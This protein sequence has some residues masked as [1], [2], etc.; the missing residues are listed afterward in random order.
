MKKNL[1]ALVLAGVMVLTGCARSTGLETEELTISCYKGVEISEVSKPEE[2]TDEE[3]EYTIQMNLEANATTKEITDRAVKSGDT[4]D[5]NFVGTTDGVAFEGGTAENYSLVIGS[6]EFIDGFEESVIGHNIGDTYDFAGT[7]EEG[8][9]EEL[10]GK[11]FVFSITVNAITEQ[12]IP[13]FNDEFVQSVS[14]ESK[15]T[16]EYREEIKKTLEENYQLQYESSIKSLAWQA[17]LDNTEV[18]YYP[19]AV[20][21]SFDSLI[22]QYKSIAEFYSMDYT[23]FIEAQMQTTV[24]EFETQMM[25]EVKAAETEVMVSQ[26]IAEKEKITMDDAKFEEMLGIMAEQYGYENADAVREA[27]SEEDLKEL[28]ITMLVMDFVAEHAMQV[29]E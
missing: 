3:V 14:E 13:E 12:V 2:V 10:G 26:A 21:E 5:I 22:G 6:G 29:A 15:T 18:K 17:V 7:F 23:E 20:Q 24:E 1:L 27:A 8:Y 9:S 19:E 4:V 28:A 11:D 16:D 25:E